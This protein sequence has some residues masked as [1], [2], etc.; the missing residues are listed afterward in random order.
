[1]ALDTRG[2]RI[3]IGYENGVVRIC[4]PLT[5]SEL[6]TLRGHT[7]EVRFAAFEPGGERLATGS[8]DTT[9]RL[10]SLEDGRLLRTFF[11]HASLVD[12]GAFLDGGVIVSASWDRTI[13][14]WDAE[15][16]QETALLLGH[17]SNV[18]ALAAD[19]TGT[20]LASGE[21]G[22]A[23]RLAP[24]RVFLARELRAVEAGWLIRTGLAHTAGHL[25]RSRSLLRK[26]FVAASFVRAPS[27]SPVLWL[28]DLPRRRDRRRIGTRPA[29]RVWSTRD[30]S[31]T[32]RYLRSAGPPPS[33]FAPHQTLPIDP[34]AGLTQVQNPDPGP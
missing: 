17:R 10:W 26:R 4:D 21:N 2:E 1:L 6:L 24:R 13:R 31:C 19:V 30:Y 25:A 20:L 9:V 11:G 29:D 23:I 5:G 3:A 18:C 7:A 12:R 27:D 14:E 15:T 32:D 22:G 33:D 34:R 16:G 28:G 8:S